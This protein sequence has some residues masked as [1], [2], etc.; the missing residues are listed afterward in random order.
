MQAA[1]AATEAIVVLLPDE[2]QTFILAASGN[3]SVLISTPMGKATLTE[4]VNALRQQLDPQQWTGS[5]A[6]YDRNRA[7]LLYQKLLAPIMALVMAL[8]IITIAPQPAEARHGRWIAAQIIT[9]SAMR[10]S[11]PRST[12]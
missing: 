8:S 7:Y 9:S 12:A 4:H 10:A 6:P 5:F 11:G 1:L 3:K 2:D